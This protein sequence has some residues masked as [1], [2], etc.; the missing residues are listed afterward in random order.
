MAK[1]ASTMLQLGTL[2]PDFRLPDTSGK[3]VS[4]A[5]FQDAPALLVIFMC[6]H[7][8]YV[9]HVRHEL[10]ELADEFQARRVAVVG[11][12][13]ND[14]ANNPDDSPAKMVE[15]VKNIGYTFPYLYDGT[16]AVAKAYRA[17]CTPDLY[18]FD[19]QR[20]L[21]YRGQ[22]DDS[23]PGSDV[24]VTGKDLREALDAVLA[25]KRVSPNQKPSIGC[26][27]KWKP[28]NEPEYFD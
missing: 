16:Q 3:I 26:N 27:I 11:I 14:A 12:N 4:S 15:E 22:F 23:R 13:S 10:A 19:R 20:R 6:N 7:C 5:D 21:V 25:G 28:G 8:P 2:A 24:P 18:L 1:T 9:K 17:A